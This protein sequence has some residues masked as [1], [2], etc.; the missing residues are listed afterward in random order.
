MEW[1]RGLKALRA[2]NVSKMKKALPELE[3][4]IQVMC[5][6]TSNRTLASLPK[7]PESED[8]QKSIDIESVCLL[9]DLVL[10][11]EHHPQVDS[12]IEYLKKKDEEGNIR[13]SRRRR[14][15]EERRRR[16]RRKKKPYLL[17][18]ISSSSSLFAF[19]FSSS[20]IVNGAA[21]SSLVLQ[22]AFSPPVS[23][24]IRS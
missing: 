22:F 18:A 23:S 19:V 14:K 5:W 6:A 8:K 13:E 4:E 21:I 10:G 7:E 2:D 20:A 16:R 3:K 9:L 17:A 11:S 1:R 15:E 24:A 12:L